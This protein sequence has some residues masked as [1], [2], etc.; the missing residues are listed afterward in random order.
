MRRAPRPTDPGYC[1]ASTFKK[2]FDAVKSQPELKRMTNRTGWERLRPQDDD[3]Q[4]FLDRMIHDLRE[5][6]RSI[7]IFSELLKKSSSGLQ[8]ENTVEQILKG[9]ARMCALID[10]ISDY[11]SAR[12]RDVS[13]PGASL[14]LALRTAMNQLGA[15]MR[16]CQCS[17]TA[18]PLPRVGADLECLVQLLNNLISNALRFRR[19]EPPRVQVSASQDAHGDW[20]VRV[21]DNGIGIDLD[22]ADVETI[23]AP[24][25]RLHG[26]KYPGVGLGLS[27]CRLIVERY[28]GR[29]WAESEA[30][31]TT[32]CFKL[33]PAEE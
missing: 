21:Q 18:E 7:T 22:P 11:T 28:G 19:D 9:A 33:P 29:I 24:F 27:I 10:G 13:A 17:V 8:G 32:F 20:T 2:A 31:G 1:I 5:P 23:F 16:A 14:D 6:L 30:Y 25:V 15:E 26:H 3:M 12:Y 4:R